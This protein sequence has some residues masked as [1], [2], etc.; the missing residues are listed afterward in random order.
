MRM[1]SRCY[2][3]L[4]LAL[5]LVLVAGCEEEQLTPVSGFDPEDCTDPNS[6]CGEGGF[7]LDAGHNPLDSGAALDGGDGDGGLI[8][9]GPDAG[10]L[11]TGV[12]DSGPADSGPLDSGVPP[13]EFLNLAGTWQTQYVFDISDY[14]FGISNIADELDFLDRLINDG[15]S[16]G[17]PPL[18]LLV[19]GVISQYIPPWVGDLVDMLSTAATLFEEVDAF[20]TMNIAQDLPVDQWAT[21]TALHASETWS[22]MYVRL[23]DQCPNGRQTTTPVPFPECAR[24]PVPIMSTPTPIGTGSNAP[25]MQVYVKPFDGVLQAG[26]PQADFVLQDREVELEL[27]KLVLIALN[28]ATRLATNGQFTTL[29]AAL[30]NAA[31]CPGLGQAAYNFARNTLGFSQAIAQLAQTTV[32]NQCNGAIQG[33]VDLIAGVGIS[34]DALEFD[35]A[36][37]AVDRN[38][39]DGQNRADVLQVLTAPDTLDG[40]FRFALSS[41]LG[42]EWASPP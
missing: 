17:F 10:L 13:S 12:A 21:T 36:G 1:R 14:L 9:G 20:G 18:D 15:I 34:W 6:T 28:A 41:D 3:L 24:V 35:Q 38:P 42:G 11:D 22:V 40:R 30:Q 31:D 5:G 27:R 37:H 7:R 23:V 16:T 2:S 25:E 39:Q 26:R 19:Q 29:Q 33:I 8:G 4:P 32:T